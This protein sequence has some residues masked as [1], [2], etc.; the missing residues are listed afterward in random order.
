MELWRDVPLSMHFL[1]R[2]DEVKLPSP[3]DAR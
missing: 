2:R 3:Q 1:A